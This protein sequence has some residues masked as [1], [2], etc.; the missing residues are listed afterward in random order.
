MCTASLHSFLLETW[1]SASRTGEIKKFK[2]RE[3]ERFCGWSKHSQTWSQLDTRREQVG[4][5]TSNSHVKSLAVYWAAGSAAGWWEKPTSS[6]EPKSGKS[7][8]H[9]RSGCFTKL[10]RREKV[11]LVTALPNINREISR[12]TMKKTSV[13]NMI[14]M[15][16]NLKN[17]PY[18]C[19]I[20][21][22]SEIESVF[23]FLL[24]CQGMPLS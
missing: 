2:K 18:I 22:A 16:W 4:W 3:R 14:T 7:N 8:H 19:F 1:R 9:H 10:A 17:P 11:W 24:V 15:G 6:W 12:G 13:V 5:D 20:L 21:S 23:S